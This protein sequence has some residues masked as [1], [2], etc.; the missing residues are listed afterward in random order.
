MALKLKTKV[1]VPPKPPDLGEN[2]ASSASIGDENSFR[3]HLYNQTV[4]SGWY[5]STFE[6][7]QKYGKFVHKIKGG[8]F[9]S[10]LKTLS[11][12]QIDKTSASFDLTHSVEFKV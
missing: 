10:R 8:G 2:S 12:N 7:E 9:V 3:K 4:V 6:S 1:L 11:S 5:V